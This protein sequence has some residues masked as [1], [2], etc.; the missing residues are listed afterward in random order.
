MPNSNRFPNSRSCRKITEH[1]LRLANSMS[2]HTGLSHIT[3]SAGRAFNV[4]IPMIAAMLILAAVPR[5]GLGQA[6]NT[7]VYDGN[8]THCAG[9]CCQE[10]TITINEATDTVDIIL[11]AWDDT[12]IDTA[13]DCFDHSCW[14]SQGTPTETFEEGWSGYDDFRIV[15]RHT[16][17]MWLGPFPIT[18]NVYICGSY[19]C[20][21]KYDNWS[22][23]TQTPW[24]AGVTQPLY[25][26][27]CQVIPP[28]SS[29]GAATLLSNQ[30][31]S[32]RIN[33]IVEP[34]YVSIINPV[35]RCPRLLLTSTRRSM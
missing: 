10:F 27:S 15:A 24:H 13:V 35:L 9:E 7:V 28:C 21:Q 23:S 1:S 12:G 33:R 18:L 25:E 4:I 16:D 11:G 20:L 30:L 17:P 6:V 31:E 5:A 3:T 8:N 14:A 34:Q 32:E 19:D 2:N 26:G 29:K 22:W